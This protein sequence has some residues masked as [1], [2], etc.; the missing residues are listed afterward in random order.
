MNFSRTFL[1]VIILLIGQSVIA[2]T[3]LIVLKI[4]TLI[5]KDFN[6]DFF[7][8]TQKRRTLMPY[9]ISDSSCMVDH[10]KNS[11]TCNVILQ[12]D[13]STIQISLDGKGGYL[14]LSNPFD[15]DYDTIRISKFTVFDR[16]YPDTNWTTINYWYEEADTLG[17][18]FKNTRKHSID[19]VKT[20]NLA[21]IQIQYNING[22]TY[23]CTTTW[24]KS[25]YNNIT[26][27]HG[28]GKTALLKGRRPFYFHGTKRSTVTINVIKL[29]LKKGL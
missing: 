19:K 4:D 21:P 22:E 23:S 7:I 25:N 8:R 1:F 16:P 9:L 2:Q 10:R 29:R 20:K 11:L 28:R 18:N 5:Q 6:D 14:E 27:F 3:K 24:Q 17:K 13:S 12:N 15:F 26:K